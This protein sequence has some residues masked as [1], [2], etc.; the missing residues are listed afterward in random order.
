MTPFFTP[1]KRDLGDFGVPK[2]FLAGVGELM[3]EVAAKTAPCSRPL[4]LPIEV[5]E[6]LE[7]LV[8]AKPAGL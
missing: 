6:M 7:A 2:I 5:N 3:T 8:R 4:P 1:D